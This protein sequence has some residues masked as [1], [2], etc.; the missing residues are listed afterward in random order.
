M[1]FIFVRVELIASA[2]ERNL[3]PSASI[4]AFLK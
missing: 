1:R 3:A 4:R 2:S